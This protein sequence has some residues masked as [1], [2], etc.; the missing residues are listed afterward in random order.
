MKVIGKQI[1]QSTCMWRDF[2]PNIN[3]LK[4]LQAKRLAY[5]LLP[6]TGI[7]IIFYYLNKQINKNCEPHGLGLELRGLHSPKV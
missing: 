6:L 3:S 4:Q 7:Y 5:S 1:S 2:S